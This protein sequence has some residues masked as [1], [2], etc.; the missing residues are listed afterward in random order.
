MD[1]AQNIINGTGGEA[2]PS[3]IFLILPIWNI[4]NCVILLASYRTGLINETNISDEKAEPLEVLFALIITLC[5]FVLCRFVFKLYWAITFSICVIY[6]TSFGE[7]L[8]SFLHPESQLA[9]QEEIAVEQAVE[10][11]V[12]L[13]KCGLCQRLIAPSETP[14]VINRKLVV[15]K[16]CYDNIQSHK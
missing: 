12:K 3:R 6:A 10:A 1:T 14:Y 2:G 15:C 9:V 8:Y 5:I 4:I 11:G 7:A 16:Q 13:E